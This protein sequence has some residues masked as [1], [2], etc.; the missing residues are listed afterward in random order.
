MNN[1]PDPDYK[2]ILADEGLPVTET[3]I[4]AEFAAIVADENLV[5]NTSQMSPFWRLITALVIAPAL[6]LVN[7]LTGA[8]IANMF[9]ATAN[10]T[11]IDLFAWAVN[12]SRKEAST[13]QGLIRFTKNTV[14]A[15]ITVPAGTVIQTERI[16]GTVYKLMTVDDAVIAAGV[17]SALV[18]V[19]AESAGSG[20]N[21]APGYFRIMPVAVGG[22]ASAV[23]EEEWLIAP[24]AD[25][26]RD[27]DLRDRVRN[28]FNLPGQYHIDAVYRGLIAGIAGLTTDRIFFLHDAPRGPGTANVYLLLDSGIASQPFID[29]VNEY[30]M[31]QGN[32]GHGDDVL[33]LPL[34]EVI[35]DL[36]VTLHLFESS[37]LDDEQTDALLA[38]V[39]NVIGCAFRENTD[40]EVQKTW[41]YSR[42]SFSRLAEEL[43]ANFAEIESLT[44]S[45]GDIVSGLS[46]PR[47]GVLTLEKANG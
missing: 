4:R 22:I 18:P 43:H 39:R 30:V 41:P 19:N 21:L 3:Q 5:T 17:I 27:N 35:Y 10:G 31:T 9:L 37:N 29:T 24:G 25:K 38:N 16:N 47:L 12:L 8:V 33:C 40:Y 28:Q 2:A 7:I 20:H 15:V 26:E 36:V 45:Q 14:S 32:H 1:R 34:P 6:W 23:N 42:Y 11:F 46:V 44:F 13:A